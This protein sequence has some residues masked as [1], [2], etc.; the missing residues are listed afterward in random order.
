MNHPRISLSHP[1]GNPNVRNAAIALWELGFLQEIIT[2]LTYDPQSNFA[3][4][5]QVLP[6]PLTR[7]LSRRTWVAPEG[8]NLRTYPLREIA[9]VALMRSR[10][11]QKLQLNPQSLVDWV[12]VGLDDRVSRHHLDGLTGVYAYEDGAAN[13]FAAAKARGIA[14]FY[15]LPIAFY[16]QSCQ[17][18]SEERETFPELAAALQSTREPAWK[19]E[20]K[21]REIQLSDRIFVPSS[22]VKQSVLN[23]GIPAEKI[24]VIPYGCPHDYFSP[25]PK[26]DSIFRALFVGRVGPRKGVH[27]LLQAWQKLNFPASELLCVGLNEFPTQW[28]AQW[29]DWVQYVPSVPHASLNEYY[30]RAS[31]FVFPSLVEGLAL[32]LL[33]AMACGIP[34]ITT[35]H[36]GGADLIEDGVEGF[37]VPIRDVTAL[38]EKLEWCYTHPQELAEMGRA[39]RRKAEVYTWELYRQRLAQ[40]IRA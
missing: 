14:C 18:Q 16:R 22:I 26:P 34:I 6:Q 1:T 12:Y 27:Y 31:V 15:D 9:R 19:L 33:E 21:E 8:V 29:Q 10:I 35:T 7:E 25:Q 36:S 13:T 24:R 4:A 11:V 32:V 5:L 20:R 23:A 2:T 39:A 40:E 30:S 17:L 37:I 28:W 38:Q 3:K